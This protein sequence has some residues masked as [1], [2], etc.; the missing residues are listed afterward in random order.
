M[1]KI[2]THDLSLDKRMRC[3]NGGSKSG[4]RGRPVRAPGL[5]HLHVAT[6]DANCMADG[7]S[8]LCRIEKRVAPRKASPAPVVSCTGSS[9]VA[10]P[11]T[12]TEYRAPE[13]DDTA[14]HEA[15][16][17]A[18]TRVP[19]L[20]TARH[21]SWGA[22]ESRCPSAASNSSRAAPMPAAGAAP[23]ETPPSDPHR[24]TQ[25]LPRAPRVVI[26]RSTRGSRDK[27]FSS[28]PPRLASPVHTYTCVPV[29]HI[30]F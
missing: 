5:R 9:A 25:T 30:Y 29:K 2:H 16:S 17:G 19:P 7:T 12:V 1:L 20:A 8:R 27:I 11:H 22:P 18:Q 3:K 26:R 21:A 28:A 10:A 14:S 23:L 4:S 13:D 15:T 24:A 6:T